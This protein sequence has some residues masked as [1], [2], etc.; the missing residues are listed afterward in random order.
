MLLGEQKKRPASQ[1]P[2]CAADK[3]TPGSLQ[4]KKRVAME[5]APQVPGSVPGEKPR[6]IVPCPIEA[7]T[8]AG[9][10]EGAAPD[11]AGPTAHC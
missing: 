11:L 5:T 8:A 4:G 6:K 10:C 9:A 7:P 3:A 1:E 2:A